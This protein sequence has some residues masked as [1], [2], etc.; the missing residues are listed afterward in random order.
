MD[1]AGSKAQPGGTHALTTI[2]G[3]WKWAWAQ[4]SMLAGT[5]ADTEV[6]RCGLG[7]EQAIDAHGVTAPSTTLKI[8]PTLKFL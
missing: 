2:V 6:C 8:A 3:S 7:P 1:C 4:T 5:L